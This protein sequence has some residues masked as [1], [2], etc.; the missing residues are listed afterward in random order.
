MTQKVTTFQNKI[1]FSVIDEVIRN[2]YLELFPS[3]LGLIAENDVCNF[4]NAFIH[5]FEL[6]NKIF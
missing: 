3:L 4:K 2:E 5:T 1:K 6:G